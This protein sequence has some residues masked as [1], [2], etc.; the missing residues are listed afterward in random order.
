VFVI[1]VALRREVC[2]TKLTDAV[3]VKRAFQLE[4]STIICRLLSAVSGLDIYLCMYCVYQLFNTVNGK[5]YIGKSTLKRHRK[6]EHFY[7]AKGG[8]EKYNT[9]FS[10]IHKAILKYNSNIEYK[11]IQ[12]FSLETD[13]FAAERYWIEFFKSNICRFGNEFGYNLTNGGDGPSGYKHT[14]E[15][16]VLMKKN[17]RRGENHPF[18]GDV[19][20]GK[21]NQTGS[22]NNNFG[23]ITSDET[24]RKMSEANSGK[25]NPNFGKIASDET[26]KKMSEVRKGRVSWN[27]G[28]KFSTEFCRKISEARKGKNRKF[29][30]EVA[31]EIFQEYLV[32]KSMPKLAA[33]YKCDRLTISSIIKR[34]KIINDK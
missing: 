12:K 28:K 10:L 25:N 15:T 19:S 22:Q 31:K 9:S 21:R 32:I 16:K 6:T 18:Y 26:R 1:N 14:E 33:K 8:K 17:C 29:S 20:W 3:V 4:T 13:A 7:V 24:K 30:D 11:I 27:K 23:K 34:L 5:I 2:P